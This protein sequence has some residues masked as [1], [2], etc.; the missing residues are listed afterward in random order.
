MPSRGSR[1]VAAERA[2]RRRRL[3]SL[4]KRAPRG[5][6]GKNHGRAATRNAPSSS[7]VPSIAVLWLVLWSQG[8]VGRGTRRCARPTPARRPRRPARAARQSTPGRS[9]RARSRARRAGRRSGGT[10]A[11]ACTPGRARARPT[12]ARTAGGAEAPSPFAPSAREEAKRADDPAWQKIKEHITP[13]GTQTEQG[14]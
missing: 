9:P 2:Y 3:H 1:A 10:P 8:T 5:D 14:K 4:A 12:A 11:R 6:G 7:C 13:I